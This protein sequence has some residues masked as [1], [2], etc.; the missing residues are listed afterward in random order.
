[1]TSCSKWK[2]LYSVFFFWV[3]VFPNMNF[4]VELMTVLVVA[5][6]GAEIFFPDSQTRRNHLLS[7][8]D[9]VMEEKKAASLGLT[10]E[11]LCRFFSNKDASGLLGLPDNVTAVCSCIIIMEWPPLLIH[12]MSQVVSPPIHGFTSLFY[13]SL[14]LILLR[15]FCSHVVIDSS[16]WQFKLKWLGSR[17]GALRGAIITGGCIEM[18]DY[19]SQRWC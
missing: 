18:V 8:V 7:M 4:W 6:A 2:G 12:F 5:V 17:K 15:E 11:S 3:K 16:T 19:L 1:M 14:W 13:Q 9:Q 10:F